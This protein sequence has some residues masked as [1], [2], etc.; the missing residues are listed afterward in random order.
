MDASSKKIAWCL[1]VLP[2]KTASA[3]EYLAKEN[4]LKNSTWYL[5]GGTALALQ[6]GYRRSVDLDFFTVEKEINNEILLQKLKA[7]GNFVT[8]VDKEGTI[9]GEL[10]NAK[11]SF[12]SY[13]FFQPVLPFLN[14]GA[15][16]ILRKEDIAVMKVVAIS[17]RGTK[18]DFFDLYYCIQ[19]IISLEEIF[20]RLKKQYPNVAHD[21]Y[22]IIKSLFYFADAEDDPEPDLLIDLDWKTVKKYFEKEIPI[23]TKKLLGLDI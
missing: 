9:Y 6:V 8:D 3:F 2:P 17:Q 12:I 10:L 19:N 21:Y 14:Y 15:V 22:H 18:R 5:A 16:N 1:D 20:V 7:G 4:W 13:P 11:I 23:L